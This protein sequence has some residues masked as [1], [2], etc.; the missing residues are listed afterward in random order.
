MTP[1]TPQLLLS[2]IVFA[3]VPLQN[4]AGAVQT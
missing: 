4:C 3:H 2:V 1:H